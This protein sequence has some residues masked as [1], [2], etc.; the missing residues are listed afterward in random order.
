VALAERMIEA[1]RCGSQAQGELLDALLTA[2][3]AEQN[4]L[5]ED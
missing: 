5:D 1:A 3:A 2:E 4:F